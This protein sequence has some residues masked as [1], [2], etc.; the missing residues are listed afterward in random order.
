M[1]SRSKFYACS[2]QLE[3]PITSKLISKFQPKTQKLVNKNESQIDLNHASNSQDSVPEM[4]QCSQPSF[5]GENEEKNQKQ[6]CFTVPI[7]HGTLVV[8]PDGIS[9]HPHLLSQQNMNANHSWMQ[10]TSRGE[11]WLKC[12]FSWGVEID[13]LRIQE[14]LAL[15]QGF[16]IIHFG[17]VIPQIISVQEATDL[18]T[19]VDV[20]FAHEFMQSFMNSD[21][22]GY[23]TQESSESSEISQN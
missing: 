8:F 15:E 21:G 22:D 6:S 7:A 4:S 16:I 18:Q 12:Y 23:N 20:L 13:E 10:I 3:K 14:E 5:I 19:V 17:T 1:L 9:R 11:I 2:S